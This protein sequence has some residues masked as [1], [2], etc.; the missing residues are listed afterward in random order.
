MSA[1]MQAD[2]NFVVFRGSKPVWSSNT[3]GKAVGGRAVMGTDGLFK[4][5][6]SNGTVQAQFGNPR[7]PGFR[8]VLIGNG[9]F[10]VVN[11]AGAYVWSPI[12][13]AAGCAL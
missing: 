6:R 10:G 9:R 8:L 1:S 13:L 12:G 4:I 7:A 11:A 3:A 2:G 5:L